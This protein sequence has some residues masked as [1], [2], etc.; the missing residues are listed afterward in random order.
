MRHRSM[1]SSFRGLALAAMIG[2]VALLAAGAEAAPP[3]ATELVP[4]APE[5]VRLEFEDIARRMPYL[6]MEPAFWDRPA[7]FVVADPAVQALHDRL[8]AKV[9]E[10]RFETSA[11]VGLLYHKEAKV[12]TLALA[13][14]IVREDPQTLPHIVKLCTD[15]SQTFDA[16]PELS[17]EWLKIANALR[18]R[19]KQQKIDY[20]AEQFVMRYCSDEMFPKYWKEHKDRTHCAGWF[21]AKIPRATQGTTP[22]Q[23]ERYAHLKKLREEIDRVPGDDAVWTLVYLHCDVPTA[24]A[25]AVIC[26]EDE[27]VELCKRLGREKILQALRRQ[28]ISDDPDLRGGFAHPTFLLR[29]AREL[30]APTDADA[31][32]EQARLDYKPNRYDRSVPFWLLAAADLQPVRAGEFL[33]IGLKREPSNSELVTKLWEHQGE[34]EADFIADWIFE[35]RSTERAFRRPACALLDAI[36]KTPKPDPRRL[37]A[38]LVRDPRLE[39]LDPVVILELVE[40]VNLWTDEPP[41]TPEETNALRNDA[42]IH[43]RSNADLQQPERHRK[44][45]AARKVVVERLRA[46]VESW[47]TNK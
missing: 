2:L 14:L 9:V 46:G 20:L 5:A 42:E 45:V 30:L 33:R 11:L 13:A 34:A 31:L 8:L 4:D 22:V 32:I 3:V 27:L 41:A 44:F 21:A 38:K 23:P 12:R 35:Q 6:A 16:H 47:S 28:T 7:R 17:A 39:T 24:S 43:W 37:V 18:P 10:P 26:P 1:E 15:K 25:A 29:H 40:V 19:L 36:S